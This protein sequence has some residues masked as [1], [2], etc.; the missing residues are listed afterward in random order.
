VKV[1]YNNVCCPIRST[2]KAAN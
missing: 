2:P 1:I